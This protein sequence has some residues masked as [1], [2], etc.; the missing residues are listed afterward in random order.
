MLKNRSERGARI[1]VIDPRITPTA[2]DAD[3]VLQIAPGM[4]QVLFSGL[5]VHLVERDAIDRAFISSH[6]DGFAEA[7]ARARHMAPDIDAIAER[8]EIA[9]ETIETFYDWFAMTA[10]A[11]TLYSQGVNQSAQG[12]DKVNAIINCHLATGRIGKPGSGP[13]SLTGQ[14]NAMG[15]REVGGLANQLAAHMD[16]EPESIDRVRRFWSAERVA[17]RPGMKAVELF[18][19]VAQGRIKALWVMST[20]PAVSLPRADAVAAALKNLDFLAVSEVLNA[21]DTLSRAADV[22]LPA[23]AWGEKD[24]TVTNSERRISRQRPFLAMPGE[25]KPDWWI[26][27][28]VAKRMGFGAAFPYV[29]AAD[30]FRE[31]ADLS[32]F[33]NEGSRDFDLSALTGISTEAYDD[34]EPVQWPARSNTVNTPQRFFADGRFFTTDH[35]ARF[36]A[37]ADASLARAREPGFPLLL[38]TGRVRDHWHTMTRTGKSPRLSAHIDEPF[39]AINPADAAAFAVKDGGFARVTTL[40]GNATLRVRLTESQRRGEIF[41]PIHWT[42]ETASDGRIGALVQPA[43]DPLSGQPELKATPATLAP[44]EF[45]AHG[46]LLRRSTLT[47]LDGV[48]WARSA[49]EGGV[50]YRLA[51]NS[52]YTCWPELARSLLGDGGTTIELSDEAQ[53]R[54]RAAIIS[55]GRLEACLFLA[56]DPGALPGWEWLKQ[57]LAAPSLADSSRRALLAGRGA[58]ASADNGPV[59]CACFAV[60]RNQICRAVTE[61]AATTPDAIGRELRAGTNCGSCV[62]ELRRI[63]AEAQKAA[64]EPAH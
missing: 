18:D 55:E 43:C 56:R 10:N 61:K 25:T 32:A 50:G 52:S 14:P 1:V 58:D 11:V 27:S 23:A 60:G 45:A 51:A 48:W 63:I 31:H 17:E 19:A 30:I 42:G 2:E 40:H 41:A 16:F 54:Y 34:L 3:L 9:R 59:V 7:L 29:C 64:V 26:V 21:T 12:T 15:G 49:I 6:T 62:P 36:V 5:F 33:E 44:L 20:N 38:N 39:V 8:C 57:Q 37:V 4:D 13:F 22:L 28:E 46:F 35:R 47:M 53:G 24:G